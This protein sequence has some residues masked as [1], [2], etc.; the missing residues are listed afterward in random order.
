M[1]EIGTLDSVLQDFAPLGGQI[2]ADVLL[3]APMFLHDT[4][5]RMVIVTIFAHIQQLK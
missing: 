4:T 1:N 3:L 5:R 2:R